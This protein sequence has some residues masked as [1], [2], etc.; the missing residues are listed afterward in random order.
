MREPSDPDDVIRQLRERAKLRANGVWERLG[1][2]Q[3]ELEPPAAVY[4][5]LRLEMLIAERETIVRARDDRA[6]DDEVLRAAMTA[7]NMEESLL[8]PVED[9]DP[10]SDGQVLVA[11]VRAGD[12]DHLRE[13]PAYVDPLTPAGC[14]ECLA[15][16]L[17]W[18][19]LRLCL[20]CGHVGCCDSSIGR[21]ATGHFKE[22]AHPVI[23]SFEPGEAWRWCYRD[24]MLG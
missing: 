10:G 18:V 15:E 7:V 6:V 3:R 21:H 24:Q 8:D 11:D 12:C 22:C 13:A 2:S 17:T 19:H 14:Q 20:T 16:G 5:R 4:R 23:R 1:R 9:A